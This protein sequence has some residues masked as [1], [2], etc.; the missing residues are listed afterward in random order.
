MVVKIS[1]NHI[2]KS[3]IDSLESNPCFLSFYSSIIAIH[4]KYIKG[5][6]EQIKTNIMQYQHAAIWKHCKA[7]E[8][9]H[10]DYQLVLKVALSIIF[11]QYSDDFLNDIF[12]HH[13]IKARA[14]RVKELKLPLQYLLMT[15]TAL[16]NIL[17]ATMVA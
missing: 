7:M 6:K 15:L 8:S 16:V 11:I 13:H 12:W 14:L 2:I 10:H 4:S 3:I 5:Y 17:G 9:D 1:Q